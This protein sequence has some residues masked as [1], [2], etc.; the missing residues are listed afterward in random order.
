MLNLGLN[1][2]VCLE[3]IKIKVGEKNWEILERGRSAERMEMSGHVI[4]FKFQLVIIGIC[5]NTRKFNC[6][7]RFMQSKNSGCR[8]WQCY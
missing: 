6:L 5:S 7:K 8:E 2:D 1:E 4:K 3:P